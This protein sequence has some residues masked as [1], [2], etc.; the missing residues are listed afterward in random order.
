MQIP[1]LNMEQFRS[2]NETQ[3]SLFVETLG[4]GLQEFGFIIVEGHEIP[5]T[6]IQKSY[7]NTK[8]FFDL[9]TAQKSALIAPIG[10]GQRGYTTSKRNMQSTLIFL[11]SK[12]FGMW[13]AVSFRT[14]PIAS[15][16]PITCG[17]MHMFQTLKTH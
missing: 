16:I 6:L 15:T 12:S 2:S 3:R 1:T 11:I 5:S 14:S 4:A 17:Q 13:G 8:Q 10:R 7:S 9:S